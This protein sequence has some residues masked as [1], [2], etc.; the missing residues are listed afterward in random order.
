MKY[1]TT[2]TLTLALWLLTQSAFGSGAAAQSVPYWMK[3][4]AS[5]VLSG[6]LAGQAASLTSPELEKSTRRGAYMIAAGVGLMAAGVLIPGL[7]ND[8]R[9]PNGG[10]IYKA[11]VPGGVVVGIGGL[12]LTA[13]GVF[14]LH[15][16]DFVDRK[17][18]DG[19][20]AGLIFTSLGTAAV[21]AGLLTAISASQLV[22][23]W[24]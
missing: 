10:A 15:K 2:F 24:E 19:D 4:S 6:Q 22:S 16:Q 7:I 21:A 8:R 5:Y 20:T 23:C 12:V 17:L 13:I 14:K 9:C 1:S 18:K 11:S 3:V